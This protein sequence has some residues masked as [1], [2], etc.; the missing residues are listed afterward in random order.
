[1]A[2][3]TK[4]PRITAAVPRRVLGVFFCSPYTRFGFSPRADF[5]P[6]GSRSSISSTVRPQH[7][8]ATVWP[9]MGFPEPGLTL[10]ASTPPVIASRKP[11]SAGLIASSARTCA[12]TGSVISLVSWPAHPSP[13][14]CTPR[15]PC[16]S[17]NPGSTQEPAASM[18]RTPGGTATSLPT[19]TILP[20]CTS[21]VPPSTG[22]PVI[23]TTRPPTI[24]TD[25]SAIRPPH[26]PRGSILAE[27]RGRWSRCRSQR[28]HSKRALPPG[29][30]AALLASL[31]SRSAGQRRAGRAANEGEDAPCP[32]TGTTRH[33]VLTRAI[34]RMT[35]RWTHRTR[36]TVTPA[37]IPWTRE[38]CRRTGGRPERASARR[39]R[40]SGRASHSISCW[41]R[42]SRTRIRMPMRILAEEEPDQDPYA[43]ADL[44]PDGSLT[45]AE[46]RAGRLVADDEGSHPDRE[47]DLVARDVGIDGGAATAEEAAVQVQDDT[48]DTDDTDDSDG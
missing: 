36:S 37:T 31:A 35:A 9:P 38:S 46:P 18:T 21:T 12:V 6:D 13:S 47:A 27:R 25:L 2:A 14:S 29:M 28:D 39:W 43:D 11:R 30:G 23:G 3:S 7:L 15:C 33:P 1:L 16:A 48:Y 22:S 45:E 19:A 20:S 24:A 4:A 17:M 8:S 10:T 26:C 44:P 5:R 41:P 42:R 34:L 40:R 32:T